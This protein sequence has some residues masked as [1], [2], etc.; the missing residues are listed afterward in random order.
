MVMQALC[1]ALGGAPL[2]QLLPVDQL[3]PAAFLHESWQWYVATT[4]LEVA[5]GVAA[6]TAL[7]CHANGSRPNTAT[8]PAKKLGP[9]LLNISRV[10]LS[11]QAMAPDRLRGSSW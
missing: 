9:V 7:A 4:A 11:H 5:P 1:C 10:P 8:A 3:P 6:A 2:D